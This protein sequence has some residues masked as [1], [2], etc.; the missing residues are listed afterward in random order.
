[1]SRHRQSRAARA[2]RAAIATT[3]IGGSM[4]PAAAAVLF[5]QL[6]QDGEFQYLSSISGNNALG[7]QVQN[8][9]DFT[10]GPVRID[11]IRWWGSEGGSAFTIRV[12]N[13]DAGAPQQSG[14]FSFEVANAPG[15]SSN[16]Y[17]G[18]T[19]PDG[20][21]F[22]YE[23][24]IPG[25]LVLAAGT[26]YFAVSGESDTWGWMG[27]GAGLSWTRTIDDDPWIALEP[28]LAFELSGERLQVIPEPG[29]LALLGW[30]ALLLGAR[31]LRNGTRA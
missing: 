23:Y 20:P 29:V 19:S 24:T 16:P 28:N 6:P 4:S 12:L 21:L 30:T 27:D 13:D 1:M 3:L 7:A 25:G 31:R 11:S 17:G 5:T 18:A 2:I 26:H 9:D 22:E 10:L 8:A 15:V 14:A